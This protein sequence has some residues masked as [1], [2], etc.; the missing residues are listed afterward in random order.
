MSEANCMVVLA[1][2]EGDIEAGREVNAIPFKGL[3]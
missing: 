2:D 1:H 3:I